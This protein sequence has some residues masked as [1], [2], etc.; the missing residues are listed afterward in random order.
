MS[1][2]PKTMSRKPKVFMT[3]FKVR[4]GGKPE[5]ACRGY[6]QERAMYEERKANKPS[7]WITPINVGDVIHYSQENR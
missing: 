7:G 1:R 5:L 3:G 4:N 6:D 2:K